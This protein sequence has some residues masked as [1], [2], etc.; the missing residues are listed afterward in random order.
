MGEHQRPH[1]L[2]VII[3]R[4]ELGPHLGVVYGLIIPLT[5]TRQV[6]VGVLG[7]LYCKCGHVLE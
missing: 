1:G 3:N 7:T 6:G 4:W 2:V 5:L